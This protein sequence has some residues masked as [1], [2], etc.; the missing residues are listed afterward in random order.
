MP[1]GL[2]MMY[3]IYFFHNGS[4]TAQIQAKCYNQQRI[5]TI[6]HSCDSILG[7]KLNLNMIS[8]YQINTLGRYQQSRSIFRRFDPFPGD[9]LVF[10]QGN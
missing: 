1:P 6:L 5:K 4:V 10:L 7:S 9:Y 8:L 2:V 3:D